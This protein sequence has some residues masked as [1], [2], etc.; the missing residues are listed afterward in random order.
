[1]LRLDPEN[2]GANY[3][4][5]TLFYNLGVY[6]IRAINADDEIPHDR[7]DPKGGR[8]LLQ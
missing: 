5:A 2:Y 7:R 3:N 1:V 8:E 6:R 4:L